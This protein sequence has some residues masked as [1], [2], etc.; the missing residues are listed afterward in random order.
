MNQFLLF[1]IASSVVAILYG[2]FLAKSILNKSPGNARMQEIAKAIQEGASAY[3]NKQYKI[4]SMIAAVLFLIIGFIPKLG[5]TMALGFLVGAVFSALAG[6]I[7]MN[8]SVRANV[9]TTEA[10]RSGI[11]SAL[12]LAFKGG[13]VTG[14]LVVGLALLGVTLFYAITLDVTALIG[15]GFGASLISVFARL[16]GGIFTKAADVGADLVGKLEAGIPEDDPRNPGVIADN[17]GDNVGD[18]AGM[19]A[20][21]FETYAVTSV[22]T[23]LLGSLL[24]V[25][26]ENAIIYPLVIGGMAI[27]ASIIGTWFV[28]ISKG[29]QP[30][31]LERKQASN[32]ANIMGALYK[33]LIASGLIAA[34]LFYPIT[35]LLMSGNGKYTVMDLFI[36]SLVGLLV[37]GALVIITEYFTSTRYSPVQ[38]IA[39]ASISGHGTNVIQG[40]AISMKSTAWP[41]ITIVLGILISYYYGGLYGIA[42]AAMS[43]L[44]MTGIIV[45]I[46]AYG[47]ITDNAGGIAEMA[48]LP[49]EVRDVTDPLDAVGNT[50]KAVTKGYAIGSAGLASLVL[51]ASYTEEIV[52][53]GKSLTFDLS[54]PYVIVGLF[55]GGLLPYYFGALCMEAVG[56]TAGKVVEEI[57]RQFREIKGIMAGTAKPDYA[58]AVSIITGAA[59]KQMILPALIPVLAP[60]LVI[61]VFGRENGWV[62]L[63]GLLVGSII[64]GLF[65]AISMTSGGGAWDN[66]KKHIE[67][68]N[69]GGKGS[70]AHK[71]AVTGDTVGDP[72]KDTAGPAI[73]PMI[74]ILN[75]VALLLVAFL[76]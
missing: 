64:T 54:N 31:N 52:K 25:E 14:L 48:E 67:Q 76:I 5:W 10:A 35:D 61:L 11:R 36:C 68:G 9:R 4:I 72:Y 47:P 75:I 32:G 73:N 22:A 74:K 66:A 69:H 70:E 27:F 56:K 20:D 40:L 28:Q 62:V 50:T 57:R 49:K 39:K 3:L 63:G 46:D 37:T 60:I 16:G 45:A 21:L 58:K 34:A 43:M 12:S 15:L 71:A 17:V 23:M 53:A 38:S 1:A 2:L 33:G 65:V 51:F 26:F 29:D 18:C 8:V 44:S 19:A 6:Y 42:V 59:I 24:F 7:G 41:L 30:S 13:T 55:I